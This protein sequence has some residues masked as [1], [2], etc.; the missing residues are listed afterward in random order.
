MPSR[1]LALYFRSVPAGTVTQGDAL[2]VFPNGNWFVAKL[3]NA[4]TMVAALNSGLSGWT[5]DATAPG[6]FPQVRLCCPW[7]AGARR[8]PARRLAGSPQAAAGRGRPAAVAGESRVACPPASRCP[9]ALPSPRTPC[10][11]WPLA[12]PTHHPPA[13][14]PLQVGGLRYAFDPS[15]PA[16]ARLVGAEV[17]A[18][19]SD[20]GA[21]GA[22]PLSSYAG[23]LLLLSTDYITGG[24]DF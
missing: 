20:G 9:L 16:D 23:D 11:P 8:L 5:G 21:S 18:D 13:C 7:P 6:R 10:V 22:T 4:S 3:V 14:P 12:H 15:L 24:G 17:L 19:F 2:S 1:L